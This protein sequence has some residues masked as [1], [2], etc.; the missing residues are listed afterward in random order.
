[1]TYTIQQFA[2]EYAEVLVAYHTAVQEDRQND[3]NSL[4]GCVIAAHN[5]LN[6]AVVRQVKMGYE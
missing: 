5:R 3:A 6:E 4:Y 1:M 2:Q